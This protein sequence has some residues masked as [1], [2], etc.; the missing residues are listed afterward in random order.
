MG[1]VL[2]PSRKVVPRLRRWLRPGA[3]L[4]ILGIFLGA[5]MSGWPAP[6]ELLPGKFHVA[7]FESG[8]DRQDVTAARW[9]GANIGHGRRVACDISLC[10]L[11]GAYAREDPLF[12]EADLYYPTTMTAGIADKIHR[13]GIEYVFV[14]LR[15]SREAPVT[16]H[17][18]QTTSSEAGIRNRPVPYAGLTK[19]RHA[20]RVRLIYNSGPIRDI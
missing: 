8:I 10:S 12:E 14:D 2:V 5:T 18:F 15:M 3:I 19:F 9:F 1:V 7:G 13:R 11:L 20:A 16:G 6:W 4:A 17:F